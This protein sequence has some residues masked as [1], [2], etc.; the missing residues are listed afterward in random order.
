[1]SNRV[2]AY[3][4]SNQ[5][6]WVGHR[7]QLVASLERMYSENKI[8]ASE[9]KELLQDLLNTDVINKTADEIELKKKLIAAIQEIINLL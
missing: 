9:Y 2:I 7:A 6:G 5:A 1:M 3:L 4:A 8:T